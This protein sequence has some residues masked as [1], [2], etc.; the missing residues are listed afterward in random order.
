MYEVI[1][2][3]LMGNATEAIKNKVSAV[4]CGTQGSEFLISIVCAAT[5]TAIRK[6]CGV[7]LKNAQPHKLYSKYALN[8]K[9]IGEKPDK[10]AF[11]YAADK[12]IAGMSKGITAVLT[13]KLITLKQK[14]LS[15][16]AEKAGKKLV[17]GSVEGKK[18]KRTSSVA[19]ETSPYL[20]VP[21]GSGLACVMLK[22][23]IDSQLAIETHV[24]GGK[25]YY[26][27]RYDTKV[28]ALGGKERVEAYVNKFAKF[29]EQ[30]AP[31]AVYLA[32]VNCLLSTGS[33]SGAHDFKAAAVA[34][35]VIN[36]LK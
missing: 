17:L 15:D 20:S 22:T 14:A 11:A 19:V 29:G 28:H 10:E 1:K 21:C 2:S 25:I 35:N 18:A 30:A 4:E 36:S 9:E 16:I 12:I 7:V 34:T 13:G 24:V 6:V 26:P 31:A 32:A 23:Y 8:I 27:S 5:G 33:M 3:K